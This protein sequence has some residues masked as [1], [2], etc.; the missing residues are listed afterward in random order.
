MKNLTHKW[1]DVRISRRLLGKVSGR[2]GILNMKSHR[3]QSSGKRK[4][5]LT[6]CREWISSVLPDPKTECRFWYKMRLRLGQD[7]GGP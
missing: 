7:N 3:D 1:K 6:V 5:R 2:R 4:N